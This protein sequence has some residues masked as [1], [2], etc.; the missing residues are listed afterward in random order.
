MSRWFLDRTGF[1]VRACEL[2]TG[3]SGS[4]PVVDGIG[5]LGNSQNPTVELVLPVSESSGSRHSLAEKGSGDRYPRSCDKS[6]RI[7]HRVNLVSFSF[8][9]CERCVLCFLDASGRY[10]PWVPLVTPI[11]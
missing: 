6:R 2:G 9:S 5:L 7:C 11:S 1:G 3:L 10:P 8:I 4:F